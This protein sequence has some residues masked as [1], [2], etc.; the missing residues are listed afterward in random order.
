MTPR[1]LL[2]GSGSERYRRYLLEAIARRFDVWL[3]NGAEA[4]WTRGMVAGW[5]GTD[6]QDPVAIAAS[7][8]HLGCGRGFDG[9]LSWD[10]SLILPAARAAEI[11]GLPGPRPAAIA[12]CRD[13]HITRRL[14]AEAGVP[15]PVSVAVTTVARAAEVAERIDYPVV[16]KPRGLGASRGVV[17]AGSR[18]DLAGA[19]EAAI[20]AT[21]PGVPSYEDLLVEEYLDGPEISVD[22]VV[23]DGRYQAVFVAHKDVG[24]APY[25]EETAHRVSGDDPLLADEPL[26][27]ILQAAHD[28][29]GL[30]QAWTHSELRLSQQGWRIIEINGRLGGDL[31]P[32]LGYLASGIEPGPAAAAIATGREPDFTARHR[33]HARIRFVYPSEDCRVTSIALP[34]HDHW[35]VEH[36]EV[37]AL[38]APGTVLRLPPSGYVARVGYALAAGPDPGWCDRAVRSSIAA[39]SYEAEPLGAAVG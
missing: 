12:A 33:R 36:L 10:E 15:Q 11:L 16:V 22:G 37:R 29:L 2:V 27:G 17:L 19:F 31:I 14:L 8:R 28:A 7:A 35:G 1:L 39:I 34:Q 3:I 18:G 5:A 20:G 9:V 26:L 25:F 30:D 6:V 13:K 32:Y 21:Y 24:H 23:R 38:A 4:A